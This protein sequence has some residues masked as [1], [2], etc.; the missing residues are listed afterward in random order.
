M[1]TRNF[2]RAPKGA[3]KDRIYGQCRKHEWYPEPKSPTGF[4]CMYCKKPIKRP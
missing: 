3:S 4:A 1:K 2:L